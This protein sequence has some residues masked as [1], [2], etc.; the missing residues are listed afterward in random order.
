MSIRRR[1]LSAEQSKKYKYLTAIALEDG[2]TASFTR[3][4]LTYS[5]DGGEWVSLPTGSSTPEINKGHTISFRGGAFTP[6][7]TYGIGTFTF[8][9]RANLVGNVM[10]LLSAEEPAESITANNAFRRLFKN[11]TNVIEVAD[12]LLPSQTLSQ[13]CYYE[14]FSGCSGL[15]NSPTLPA[16]ILQSYCYRQ[17]FQSCTSLE[18]AGDIKATTAATYCCYSMFQDCSNLVRVQSTLLPTEVFSN[19][20][21]SMFLG[22][23]SLSSAPELPATKLATRC[24]NSMFEGCT[25]LT[26]APSILPTTTNTDTYIYTSMFQGCTSLVTAPRIAMTTLK[27]YCCSNMFN[28]CTSLVNVYPLEGKTL[29]TNCYYRMFMGC[30][31]LSS[32]TMLATAPTNATN[33]SSYCNSWLDGVYSSGT[34]TVSDTLYSYI[35]TSN[36]SGCPSGWTLISNNPPEEI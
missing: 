34:L 35:T 23:T 8:T 4:A 26:K 30:S 11:N 15:V 5:I 36:V 27:N 9:K 25:S 12:D 2:F 16:T 28:G 29:V 10:S 14:M 22:C 32:V 24:Y 20:Y 19:S 17:M 33:I 6:N 21:N 7:S 13:Y 1:L 31:S 18:I 3:N